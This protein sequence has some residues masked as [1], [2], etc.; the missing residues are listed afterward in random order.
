[1]YL[2][3]YVSKTYV[4]KTTK[5]V[6]SPTICN[7]EV[8]TGDPDGEEID[9]DENN[10]KYEMLDEEEII[11]EGTDLITDTPE[12]VQEEVIENGTLLSGNVFDN[13]IDQGDVFINEVTLEDNVNEVTIEENVNEVTIDNI[14]DKEVVLDN[15]LHE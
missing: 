10:I 8:I 1:M 6:R 15:M 2:R 12:E 13:V 4:L 11:E 5:M 3:H 7:P 9:I 14:V